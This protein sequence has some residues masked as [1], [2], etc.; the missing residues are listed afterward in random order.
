MPIEVAVG[1]DLIPSIGELWPNIAGPAVVQVLEDA[2]AMVGEGW[3]PA[4]N[5]SG[6][7]KQCHRRVGRKLDISSIS[8]HGHRPS[9]RS[10]YDAQPRQSNSNPMRDKNRLQTPPIYV[11]KPYLRCNKKAQLLFSAPNCLMKRQ[12]I[13]SDHAII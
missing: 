3:R 6:L 2:D 5:S 4:L 1:P 13:I 9:P 10:W 12:L 11:Q 7:I 8:A